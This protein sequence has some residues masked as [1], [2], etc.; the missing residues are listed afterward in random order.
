MTIQEV[1]ELSMDYAMLDPDTLQFIQQNF[2]GAK[3]LVHDE[4][5]VRSVAVSDLKPFDQLQAITDIPQDAKIAAVNAETQAFVDKHGLLEFKVIEGAGTSKPVSKDEQLKVGSKAAQEL[6]KVRRQNTVKLLDSMDKAAPQREKATSVVEEMLDQGRIGKFSSKGV[7]SMVDEIIKNGSSPALKAIAGLRNSDQ[8]YAHCTDMSVIL[9][10]AY[11]DML[12]I[13]G[14]EPSP[15]NRRFALIAGFM[16]DIGKSELPKDVLDSPT[17]FQPDSKEMLIMRNHVVYGAKILEQMGMPPQIINVAHFHHVKS[18]RSMIN[19]YPS[20][21]YDQVQPLTR[22]AAITDVYQA[23]IGRRK[24]KR[25]WVPGKAVEYLLGLKGT[26]FDD[27]ILDQFIQVVG[28]YPVGSLVRLSTGD[29]G[30][31][32]QIGPREFPDRPMVAVVENA[33]GE[34][35]TSQTLV[36]LMVEASVSV[37]EVVD[38]YEHYN[39][40]EEQ[41]F[42]IFKSIHV[43]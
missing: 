9:Q 40:S 35:L 8:T 15:A 30:F 42:Q 3:A 33:K 10:E 37:K 28:K 14:R 18:D 26:E 6:S 29:L 11:T 5:G 34:L 4:K 19:S 39:K 27:R 24:Y 13:K 25:N 23:L 16:H 12:A 31:V 22:L 17:R 20:V 32:M 36:D 1:T 41:A 43:S 38:H 7:E 2:K 21:D